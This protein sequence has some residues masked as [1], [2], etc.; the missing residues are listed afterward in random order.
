MVTRL[1]EKPAN[2]AHVL[3][4]DDAH[5]NGRHVDGIISDFNWGG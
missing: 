1:P 4:G 3:G 5:R 2:A